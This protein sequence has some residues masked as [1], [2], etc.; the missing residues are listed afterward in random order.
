MQGFCPLA[1]GSKGNALYLGTEHTKI[2]IDAGIS[3]KSIHERLAKI[4][5]DMSSIDA[6]VVTHE[7]IDHIRA[8]KVLLKKYDIPILCNADTAKGVC[9]ALHIYPKFKIF[10]TGEIFE[11]K[12]LEFHPFSIRHDTLDPV[13]MSIK[14]QNYKLGICTDLGVVSSIV[15]RHL[16]SCDFLFVEANHHPD[17]VYSSRRPDIYK[18]RVLGRQGHLSN[19]ECVDL[20]SQ[21]LHENLRHIYLA[22]LSSE[23]NCPQLALET[24]TSFIQSKN[25]QIPVSIAYQDKISQ[26]IEF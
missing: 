1:S 8:L 7:H 5:V 12:D 17:M 6:I 13:G 20:L 9:E 10:T 15:V 24:I 25:M 26:K 4:S 18:R 11:Y 2:L 21:V 14:Y 3:A 19:Q 16:Q 22:H 23:C